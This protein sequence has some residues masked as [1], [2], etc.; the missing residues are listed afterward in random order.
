MYKNLRILFCILAVI[1]A[2]VTIFIF[3]YFGWWGFVPLGGG[4]VFAGLMLICKRAQ[5]NEELKKNPPPPEG[6]YLTG[7]V[8]KNEE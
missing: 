6:D 8:H 3:T 5:E 1:C 2:A 4:L 7:K